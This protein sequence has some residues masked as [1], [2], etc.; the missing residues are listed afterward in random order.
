ML[1]IY[2][3]GWARCPC[4]TNPLRSILK[5]R[6]EPSTEGFVRIADERPLPAHL[7]EGDPVSSVVSGE[8]THPCVSKENQAISTL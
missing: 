6:G 7:V 5:L 2:P 3:W 4:D 1:T 8:G